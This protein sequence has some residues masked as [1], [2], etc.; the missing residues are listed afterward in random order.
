MALNLQTLEALGSGTAALTA[1]TALAREWRPL[2]DR[3]RDLPQ[4]AWC[5][6]G[7]IL[8]Q[9]LSIKGIGTSPDPTQSSTKGQ[10]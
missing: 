4:W 9:Y 3:F 5:F 10:V 2:P 8:K 6:V 1:L 7:D